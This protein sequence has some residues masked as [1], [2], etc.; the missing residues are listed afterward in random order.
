LPRGGSLRGQPRGGRRQG[1]KNKNCYLPEGELEVGG[2]RNKQ[3]NKNEGR[4]KELKNKKCFA[5]KREGTSPSSRQQGKGIKKPK[6]TG[7]LRGT[8]TRARLGE[9]AVKK[10]MTNFLRSILHPSCL[11][12]PLQLPCFLFACKGS[13]FV[14]NLCPQLLKKTK[15]FCFFKGPAMQ[16]RARVKKQKCYLCKQESRGGGSIFVYLCSCLV[17][18]IIFIPCPRRGPSSASPSG[19]R[20]GSIFCFLSLACVLPSAALVESPLGAKVKKKIFF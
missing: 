8:S 7:A 13:I 9:G 14:F 4:A 5:S 3:N 20:K 1:I 16:K 2:Q 11:L 15:N 10:K 18:M 12:R 17:L 6:I 19:R